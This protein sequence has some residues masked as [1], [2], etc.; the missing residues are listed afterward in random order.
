[1]RQV[2]VQTTPV[3]NRQPDFLPQQ[4]VEHSLS[5]K[6][7]HIDEQQ[8]VQNH[9]QTQTKTRTEARTD[10]HTHTHTERLVPE[11][12]KSEFL[13]KSFRRSPQESFQV[14]EKVNSSRHTRD[15]C[16]TSLRNVLFQ[17]VRQSLFESPSEGIARL[18]HFARTAPRDA[19]SWL[20][21]AVF[22]LS[23]ISELPRLLSSVT[24]LQTAMKRL[25]LDPLVEDLLSLFTSQS[26]NMCACSYVRDYFLCVF[27]L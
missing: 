3:V 8:R 23:E 26:V 1:M 7:V 17:L 4:L 18:D 19:D 21:F 6:N 10:T 16:E 2:R 25:A 15:K 22:H 24:K 14:I 20:R 27:F 9:R 5:K 13:M 12:K 11:F